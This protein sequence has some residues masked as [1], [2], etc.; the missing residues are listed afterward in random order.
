[1]IQQASACINSYIVD[2]NLYQS[3]ED[4]IDALKETNVRKLHSLE[5]LNDYAVTL[6]YSHQYEQAIKILKNLEL[7]FPNHPKIVAN[8][9]AAYELNGELENAKYWISQG[10]KRDPKIH[11]AVSEFI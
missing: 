9:G 6:S 3:K 11:G 5:A 8:L 10:M 7:R 1:M 2:L 4:A